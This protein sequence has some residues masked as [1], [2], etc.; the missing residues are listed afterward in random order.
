MVILWAFPTIG[1]YLAGLY[2]ARVIPYCLCLFDTSALLSPTAWGRKTGMFYGKLWQFVT[3]KDPWDL[4]EQGAIMR[5]LWR[6]IEHITDRGLWGDVEIN[7]SRLKDKSL[8]VPPHLNPTVSFWFWRTL[9]AAVYKPE[10]LRYHSE[11]RPGTIISYLLQVW[12]VFFFTPQS[13]Q[14][15]TWL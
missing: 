9:T 12:D 6:D 2:L 8:T 14:T 15:E 10:G 3:P 11:T 7:E 1:R 13:Q 4:R 5:L